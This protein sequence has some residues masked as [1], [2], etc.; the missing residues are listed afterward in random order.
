MGHC[1]SSS[2]SSVSVVTVL[3][4]TVIYEQQQLPKITIVSSEP[5]PS[6]ITVIPVTTATPPQISRHHYSHNRPAPLSRHHHQ[7]NSSA[8]ATENSSNVVSQVIW[9]F[10]RVQSQQISSPFILP[11]PSIDLNDFCNSFSGGVLIVSNSESI[12]LCANQTAHNMLLSNNLIGM[13]FESI[14]NN[15][16][17]IICKS[18]VIPNNPSY[19]VIELTT[20]TS[21]SPKTTVL[22]SVEK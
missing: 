9:P 20:I 22:G 5:E 4:K 12:I 17:N 18:N 14:N 3:P 21:I 16:R 7:R 1:A 13:S 10:S 19:R 15:T 8:A 6:H 11:S 2:S